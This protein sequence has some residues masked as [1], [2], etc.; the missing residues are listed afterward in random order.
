MFFPR[1]APF[2]FLVVIMS[3]CCILSAE[4]RRDAGDQNLQ[5]VAHRVGAPMSGSLEQSFACFHTIRIVAAYCRTL[6]IPLFS[7]PF[8]VQTGAASADPS[9]PQSFPGFCA[10]SDLFNFRP[11]TRGHSRQ[12]LHWCIQ[13]VGLV[14]TR[15][16]SG[17][18]KVFRCSKNCSPSQGFLTFSEEVLLAPK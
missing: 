15:G 4:A 9:L 7:V 16:P 18:D 17:D 2:F 8:P 6:D 11:T 10:E 13:A 3:T 12:I 5:V 14:V 1:P